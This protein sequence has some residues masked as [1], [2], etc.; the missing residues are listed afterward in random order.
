MGQKGAS[1]MSQYT[2]IHEFAK[3]YQRSIKK[4]RRNINNAYFD[5]I[6]D[7]MTYN[8]NKTQLD[9]SSNEVIPP[10]LDYDMFEKP[11]GRKKSKNQS[12]TPVRGGKKRRED[13]WPLV[14]NDSKLGFSQDEHAAMT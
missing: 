14:M 11:Y 9:V 7:E 10:N 13:K 8:L 1:K 3:N 12:K 4:T 5:H 6:A 2:K